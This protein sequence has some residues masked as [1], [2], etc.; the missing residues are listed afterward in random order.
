VE[1][2][3]ILNVSDLRASFDW[4]AKLGWTKGWDWCPPDA[5]EPT[6]GAV[7]SGD[8]EIFL[9]LDGQGGRGEHGTW[10]AL[11][12]DD[13][14]AIH[15]T[16]TREGFDVIDGPEDKPWGVREM[17][18]RHPD[19]HVLRISAEVPHEHPHD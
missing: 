11:W 12:V 1:V 6:F 9:C 18:V 19:G 2:T 5:S 17:H 16:S 3:P 15:G 8:R 13:V 4:F 10:L 7:A 14:D